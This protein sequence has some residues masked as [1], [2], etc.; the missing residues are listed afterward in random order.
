MKRVA[1]LLVAA[2]ALTACGGPGRPVDLAVV[3][4]ADRPEPEGSGPGQANA[5]GSQTPENAAG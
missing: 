1:L 4:S 3:T 2:F 5:A